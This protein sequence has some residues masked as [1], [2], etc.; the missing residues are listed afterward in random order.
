MKN[1]N[2]IL[3]ILFAVLIAI[4]LFL[5]YMLSWRHKESLAVAKL[6]DKTFVSSAL[7]NEKRLYNLRE[8][9]DPSFARQHYIPST[10]LPIDVVVPLAG[11]DVDIAARCVNAIKNL[12][13]HKIGNIYLVAPENKEI[14]LLAAKLGCKFVHEDA[15]LPTKEIKKYGG[16][17]IQQFLKLNADS[18]VENEHYLVVDADTILI[19]PVIFVLKDNTYLVNTH[20]DCSTERKKV[21]AIILGNKKVFLYD[22]VTHHMFFSKKILKN[23]KDHIEKRFHKRWDL[24][25]MDMFAKEND[26]FRSGFSEYDLYAT[27]LTEFSGVKFKF[28][29]NANVTVYRNFLDRLEYIIPAYASQYKT[30]SLHRGDWNYPNVDIMPKNK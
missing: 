26:E 13:G 25:I 30:I 18:I 14:R 29:S 22:F 11:K 20:W 1:R 19:R 2:I 28:I 6:T 16:W 10:Q 21:S 15:V 7:R 8:K 12:V 23:M 3:I 9:R 4:S 17:F 27:Y 5:S 24:A